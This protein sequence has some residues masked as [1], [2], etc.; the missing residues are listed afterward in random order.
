VY[1]PQGCINKYVITE[2]M[3]PEPLGV[4]LLSVVVP[5]DVDPAMVPPLPP[6][7]PP[8]L[9]AVV[10]APVAVVVAHFATLNIKNI[11]KKQREVFMGIRLGTSRR[12]SLLQL[13][14]GQN[15]NRKSRGPFYP[16]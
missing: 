11:S 15:H 9:V 7:A 8:L 4:G 5:L 14:K 1:P 10:V 16:R 3:G 2:A 12:S 13:S 6:V